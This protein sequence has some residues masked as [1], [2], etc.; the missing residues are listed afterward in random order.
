MAGLLI[1]PLS[2]AEPHSGKDTSLFFLKPLL[3]NTKNQLGTEIREPA[4]AYPL[5]NLGSHGSGMRIVSKDWSLLTRSTEV[6]SRAFL[7]CKNWQ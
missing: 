1:M 7:L 2:G 5:D 3:L 4:A 6:E